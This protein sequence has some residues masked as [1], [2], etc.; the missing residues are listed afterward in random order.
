MGP[1]PKAG[2]WVRLEVEA[3]KVGLPPGAAING[4]A[5]TQYDGTHLLGQ[6]RHRHPHAASRHRLRVAGRVGGVRT[7]AIKVARCPIR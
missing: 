4:W 3:E 1:L 2:E 5:F 6:G 7:V